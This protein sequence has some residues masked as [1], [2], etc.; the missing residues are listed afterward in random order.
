MSSA[1][2]AGQISQ[3]QSQ[4]AQSQET[5]NRLKRELADVTNIKNLQDANFKKLDQDHTTRNNRLTKLFSPSERAKTARTYIPGMEADLRTYKE[6]IVALS[7]SIDYLETEKNNKN[8][9]LQAEEANLASLENHLVYL[10]DTYQ[11]WLN[12]EAEDAAA[13]AAAATKNSTK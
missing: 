5:I 2:L 8:A 9:E 10:Q 6:T 1:V 13:A 3:C 4:I 11:Y 12:R 7:N